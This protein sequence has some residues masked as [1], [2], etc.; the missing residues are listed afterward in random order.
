ML[1]ASVFTLALSG[2]AAVSFAAPVLAQENPTVGGAAMMADMNIVE[3]AV[4]SPINTTLVAAVVAADLVDTL[5][6]PGPFTVFAPTDEAFEAI[7]SDTLAQLL[8]PENKAQLQQILACHVVGAEAFSSDAMSM[9]EAGGGSHVVETLGGCML[10]LR[11]DGDTL[12][13]TDERGQVA[14]VIVADVDQS[15]GVIHV[16]D[17]V[18]L[19][20]Q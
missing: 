9:I 3:N 4:N 12:T 19:P 11:M 5:S 6:G 10:T 1:K 2:L 15:N 7:P 20:T 16:I 8:L 13:V 17:T 18:L 14:N